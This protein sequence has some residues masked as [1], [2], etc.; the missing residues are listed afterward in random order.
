MIYRKKN[1]RKINKFKIKTVERP[2][3]VSTV[4][5][6]N[7]YCSFLTYGKYYAYNKSAVIKNCWEHSVIGYNYG[8]SNDEWIYYKRV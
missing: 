3:K 4:F 5:Y 6:L 7:F 8:V 1:F 2:W